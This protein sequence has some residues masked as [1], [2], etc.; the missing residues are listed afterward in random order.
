MA[1]VARETVV[2]LIGG[3]A[4]IGAMTYNGI[5]ETGSR[6]KST[7]FTDALISVICAGIFAVALAIC[8]IRLGAAMPQTVHI[9]LIFFVGIAIVGFVVLRILAYF[10]HRRKMKL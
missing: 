3:V 1:V 4:Y 5:W 6:F 7:P 2:L 8:Y 9:A 10:S